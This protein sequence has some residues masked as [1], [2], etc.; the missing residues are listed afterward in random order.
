MSKDYGQ[1]LEQLR[2]GE[3]TEVEISTAKFMD[4]QRALMEYPHRKQVVGHAKRGGGASYHYNSG[5]EHK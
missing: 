1:I 5:T 3:I 4:F 2:Q